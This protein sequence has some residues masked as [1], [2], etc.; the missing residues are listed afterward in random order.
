MPIPLSPDSINVPN[1]IT[2]VL[3]Y[4]KESHKSLSPESINVL[5]MIT[6]V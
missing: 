2:N 4:I 1:M 6:N 5:N 3:I